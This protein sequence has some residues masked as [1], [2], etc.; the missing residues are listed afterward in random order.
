MLQKLSNVVRYL[1]PVFV[2][3]VLVVPIVLDYTLNLSILAV[4]EYT[5]GV[6]SI[7]ILLYF[8]TQFSFAYLNQAQKRYLKS[9]GPTDPD[10]DSKTINISVVGY[11]EDPAYFKQ[12]LQSVLDCSSKTANFN[13]LFVVIDGNDPDDLYMRDIFFEIFPLESCIHVAL[14]DL[15]SNHTGDG[16]SSDIEMDDYPLSNTVLNCINGHKFVCVTQPHAGKRQA[17]YTAFKMSIL[18]NQYLSSN[19]KAIFCNDSDTVVSKDTAIQLYKCLKYDNV[20]AS[21]GALRMLNLYDSFVTFLVGVR[22]WFAFFVERGYQSFN[23]C[24]LCVS[25]PI[26]MYKLECIEPILNSWV[27]QTFLNRECTY[28]DDRHLTIKILALG[29]QV[30]FNPL[31]W[32]STETPKTFYRFYKQQIRWAK[33]SYREFLWNLTCVHLHSV[34][35]TV[36]L[37]YQSVYSF[38]VLFLLVLIIIHGDFFVIGVYFTSVFLIGLLKGAYASLRERNPEYLFFSAYGLLFFSVILPARIFALLTM[39]DISWGTSSRKVVSN[40]LGLDVVFLFFYYV[41]LGAGLGYS[42]YSNVVK[43]LDNPDLSF[44]WIIIPLCLFSVASL[45]L[46]VYLRFKRAQMRGS[47]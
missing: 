16:P 14:D 22:Y 4:D 39:Y 43:F 37:T 30:V 26:G 19:V 32:S 35:M 47:P 7:F 12:C 13:R 15:P 2:L 1:V 33:S 25:G 18:E 41:A 24:V 28:G 29:K 21:T 9:D 34:F 27:N 42:L 36:D 8:I 23:K 45:I 3:S 5:I 44:I 38:V 40:A 10:H 31:A 6:Y 20:G 17:L 46:F 11:R